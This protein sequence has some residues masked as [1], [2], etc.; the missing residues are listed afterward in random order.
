MAESTR[1]VDENIKVQLHQLN[2]MQNQLA[3]VNEFKNSV[4]KDLNNLN[5]SIKNFGS[6]ISK[7][8]NLNS[9]GSKLGNAFNQ[10]FKKLVS[11]LS[12]LGTKIGNA[13][14]KIKGAITS[15][16]KTIGGKISGAFG[17]FKDRLKRLNPITAIKDKAK[18]IVK[19]PITAIKTIFGRNDE[20][21]KARYYKNW[22]SPKKVAKIFAKELN[23]R[24]TTTVTSK[25]GG[26]PFAIFNS[27]AG[28]ISA[29]SRGVTMISFAVSFFFMGPGAGIAIAVGIMPLVALLGVAF[30]MLFT[31]LKPLIDGIIK[32]VIPIIQSL[33]EKI[34]SFIDNPAGF[35][36]N[37]YEGLVKGIVNGIFE[38]IDTL[39]SN[40]VDRIKSIFGKPFELASQAVNGVKS[41][42]GGVVDKI[43]GGDES[44][45]EGPSLIETLFGKIGDTLVEIKDYITDGRFSALLKDGFN[46]IVSF[47]SD[48]RLADVLKSSVDLILPLLDKIFVSLGNTFSTVMSN[49]ILKM[50]E[51][52]KTLINSNKSNDITNS[53]GNFFKNLKTTAKTAIGIE[54]PKTETN[55]RAEEPS[56]PFTTLIAG[57]ENMHKETLNM[58][59]IISTSLLNIEKSKIKIDDTTGVNRGVATD[60]NRPNTLQ[61]IN[62][63]NNFDMSGVI[64]E[65]AKTNKYLDGILVNTSLDVNGNQQPN[66]VWSI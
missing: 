53:I 32:T 25:D 49:F 10:G 42:V 47:V 51:L 44:K 63:S 22:N 41:F 3:V 64:D 18:N 61:N 57:F 9:L 21:L 20:Q 19:K 60:G 23:K 17:S 7:S 24:K 56:N 5:G 27:I 66:A 54:T 55:A 14:G 16:F 30:Y 31:T 58:L 13:F 59:S 26:N 28:L 50:D 46:E 2:T 48:G 35:I 33:G 38:V 29:I 11:P 15:P 37:V 40:I 34:I 52:V 12:N 8:F 1:S 6:G 65:L 39:V 4:N 43:T 36:A 45:K 62:V